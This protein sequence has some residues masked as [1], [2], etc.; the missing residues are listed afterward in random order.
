MTQA[1]EASERSEHSNTEIEDVFFHA[2][3]G[4]PF[5]SVEVKGHLETWPVQSEAFKRL[6][7]HQ[8]WLAMGTP[9]PSKLLKETIA[10]CDAKACFDGPERKVFTRIGQDDDG[11]IVVDLVNA[12]WQVAVITDRGWSVVD[13]SPIPFMRRQGM[14]ALPVPEHGGDIS[15]LDPYLNLASENDKIL[16]LSMLLGC[17]RPTGP[18]PLLVLAGQYGSGKSTLCNVVRSLVD[19]NDASVAGMPKDER[20]LRIEASKSWLQIFD[21]LSEIKPDLSDPLCRLATGGAYRTR[22]LY[23]NDEE[24]VFTG[25]RPVILNSI[26]QGLIE[27]ADLADRSLIVKTKPLGEIGKTAEEGWNRQFEADRPFILGALL[28]AL[29]SALRTLPSVSMKDLPRMADFARWCIAGE[30]GLGF[31][32]GSFKRAYETNRALITG[33]AL[34]SSPIHEAILILLRN[35][36]YWKGDVKTLYGD[37]SRW[38]SL[39]GGAWPKTHRALRAQLD[40][41]IPGL[42]REGIQVNFLGRDGY[43]RRSVLE[44][45]GTVSTKELYENN[46]INQPENA[47]LVV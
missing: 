29:S 16:F 5:A 43:T 31:A 19:P 21:N 9:M 22:K 45:R 17:F 30:A 41:I 40:R 46:S 4:E 18:F 15:L 32:P 10:V 12:K 24:M 2:P 34:D 11:N 38:R 1:I 3:N 42:R 25:S 37:L 7:R 47:T 13:R 27:A 28:T 6:V 23:T 20:N 44:I 35:T 33:S 8:Y 39:D 14:T 36:G 26:V